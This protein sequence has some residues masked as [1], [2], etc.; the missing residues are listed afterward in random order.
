MNI[1]NQLKTALAAANLPC[2][3]IAAGDK[4]Q[5]NREENVVP[6]VFL[7]GTCADSTWR[8]EL[9]PKLDKAGV[10]YFNPIVS[11]W[12]EE[13]QN[14]EKRMRQNCTLVLCVIT[15]EMTGVY[16]IAEAVDSAYQRG[17]DCIFCVI[18]DG[19]DEGQVKSLKA[20]SDLIELRGGTVAVSLDDIVAI[21]KE[22]MG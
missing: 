3:V 2:V 22:R 21:I 20:V 16:S 1:V 17:T 14:K 10:T 12:N 6:T 5:N 11:D 9:M 15:K 18:K 4:E 7:G 13:A 8:D 19:F